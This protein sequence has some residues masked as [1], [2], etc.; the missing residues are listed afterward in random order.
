MYCECFALQIL[1]NE[2]CSCDDCENLE[3]TLF[4]DQ[5][6][7]KAFKRNTQAFKV[8]NPEVGFSLHL[9]LNQV[10]KGCKCSKIKC[11]KKYC[12][13][14]KMGEKCTVF[15]M[16]EDCQNVDEVMEE[17][18]EGMSGVVKMEEEV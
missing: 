5:A 18:G 3:Q 9:A 2:N 11:S 16:C 12:E 7:I 13:C 15:C 17:E 4:H 10:K 1:C 14:L 8:E 6:V